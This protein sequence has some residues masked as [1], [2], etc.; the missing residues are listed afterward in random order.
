MRVDRLMNALSGITCGRMRLEMQAL[1][2]AQSRSQQGNRQRK[3]GAPAGAA[4]HRQVSPARVS[5]NHP[6]STT[7]TP[8]PV[9][10][11]SD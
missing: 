2:P 9:M 8:Y 5:Q 1:E 11:N 7:G 4:A 10:H 6:C 3:T